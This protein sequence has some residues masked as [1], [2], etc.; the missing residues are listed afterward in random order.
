[1]LL[2]GRYRPGNA[3]NSTGLSKMLRALCRSQNPQ[4]TG[5]PSSLLSRRRLWSSLKPNQ[6]K[7]LWNILETP[8]LEQCQ[9]RENLKSNNV[10]APRDQVPKNQSHVCA[11]EPLP[12][13]LLKEVGFLRVCLFVHILASEYLKK[14]F[15]WLILEFL[16]NPKPDRGIF[17]SFTAIIYTY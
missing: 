4:F 9:Q 6:T 16:M 13:R 7:R 12:G 1:M 8:R 3:S 11:E 5:T 17:Y 15:V 14:C 10:G 2:P